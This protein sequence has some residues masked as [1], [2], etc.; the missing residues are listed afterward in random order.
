[1]LLLNLSG[2]GVDIFCAVDT[3]FNTVL[4]AAPVVTEPAVFI[5]DTP[6]LVFLVDTPAAIV[7]KHE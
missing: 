3:L 2:L 5:V 6:A 7:I 1:M 4:W